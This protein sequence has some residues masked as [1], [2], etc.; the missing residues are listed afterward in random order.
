MDNLTQ[1][2]KVLRTL[3]QNPSGMANYQLSRIA[4][5]YTKVIS[6]LRADGHKIV[7]ERVYANGRWTGTYMYRLIEP[8]QNLIKKLLKV[9]QRG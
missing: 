2:S 9:G 4:L 6:N 8:K 7:T 1:S 3:K 5:C